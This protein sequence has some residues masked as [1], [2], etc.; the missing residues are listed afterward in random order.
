MTS[1]QNKLEAFG[2][3]LAAAVLPPAPAQ[4]ETRGTVSAESEEAPEVYHYFRPQ[5]G[6]PYVIWAEDSEE[7]SIELNN[8]KAEQQIH[9][10]TDYF[11]KTEYDPVADR[12]QAYFES[13]EEFGWRLQMVDFEDDTHTIHFE[14]EW[15]L[16]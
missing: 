5:L 8:K 16:I 6:P 9:G 4:A 12:I 11:T 2:T 3:G 14:W 15:W 1:L 13:L 7:G 10:T